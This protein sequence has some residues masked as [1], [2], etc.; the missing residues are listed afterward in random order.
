MNFLIGLSTVFGM[1]FLTEI[2]SNRNEFP[3]KNKY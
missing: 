2:S 3:G 1:N